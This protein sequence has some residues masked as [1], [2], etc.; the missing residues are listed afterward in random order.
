MA[1][2]PLA[3]ALASPPVQA[4]AEPR[5]LRGNLVL[6][7]FVLFQFACQLL[8]ITSVGGA[9]RVGL[10][11]LMF[12]ASIALFLA[13]RRHRAPIHDSAKVAV[14]IMALLGAQML[15]PTTNGALSGAAHW[16][17]Y[18]A[19]L[20]PL[21]WVPRLKN[22]T[23][24]IRRL[25]T[26][27]W[28]FHVTSCVFAVLQV[29]YP[30]QFQPNLSS[31]IASVGDN[32]VNGLTITTATGEVTFR[33]MGLTDTP[34]GAGASGVY[35]ALFGVGIL[36]GYRQV[37]LRA[38]SMG[39]VGLGMVA[40][41]L[42]QVRL[43]FVVLGLSLVAAGIIIM[44]RRGARWASGFVAAVA[45]MGSLAYGWALGLVGDTV[46]NRLETLTE[47]DPRTVYYRNRGI[48]L[49]YTVEELIPK[50]PVG[51]GLGRWGMINSYLGSRD[52]PERGP[53][54]AE[55]Q[56]TGWVYDGGV[57]MIALY[58]LALLLAMRQAAWIAVKAPFSPLW[59]WAAILF[60]YDVGA[61]AMTFSYPVFI[62]Q[63]GMEF[64]L[65]NAA[66]VSSAVQS[67]L[68]RLRARQRTAE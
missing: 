5:L 31:A 3:P 12:V 13:L 34:G 53:L 59:I 18:F 26:V 32:Y 41:Y 38:M 29:V 39:S 30:G 52:D 11:S 6:P 64:W 62:G 66:L 2:A 44:L 16:A 1:V 61:M 65:F 17:L 40:V 25:I 47:E 33:P 45:L 58:V 57:L 68:V 7:A 28:L 46:T 8:L 4:P 55:I 19:I 22:G 43:A 24:A 21:F 51:A 35:A 49:E 56:L 63:S 10:R 60:A 15:H 48:F 67:G 54:W 42:S 36:F 9:I 37:W 27:F 23:D 14:W 20:G 50:F